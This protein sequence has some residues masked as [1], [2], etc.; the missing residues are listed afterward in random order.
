VVRIE[1]SKVE[2]KALLS[3]LGK[4]IDGEWLWNFE[5]DEKVK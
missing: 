2:S 4:N 5:H 3:R 1:H